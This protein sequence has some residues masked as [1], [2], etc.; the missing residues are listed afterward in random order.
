MAVTS[1]IVNLH[2]GFLDIDSIEGKGTLVTI[3]LP[4]LEAPQTNNNEGQ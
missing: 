2:N 3:M 4:L 1:E